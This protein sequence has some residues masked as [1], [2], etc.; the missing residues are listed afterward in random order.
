[1]QPQLRV[2]VE[3]HE[4]VVFSDR[5]AHLL[6]AIAAQGSLSN[7]AVAAGL[8]YRNAWGRIRRAESG[9]GMKLVQSSVGGAGGGGS[10]LTEAG[11][12]LVA[13]YKDF[14]A[15]L[16]AYAQGEFDRCF[17][18]GQ[19]NAKAGAGTEPPPA[20]TPIAQHAEPLREVEA[21]GGGGWTSGRARE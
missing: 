9:L 2:W 18:A 12:R 17:G 1:V 15:G 8:S 6:E 3:D 4:T 20:T 7:G 10:K 21:L 16:A 5:E 19:L 11:E 13:R 14:R